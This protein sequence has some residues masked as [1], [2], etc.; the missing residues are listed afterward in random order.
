MDEIDEEKIREDERKKIEKERKEERT[1]YFNDG[2]SYGKRELL[3]RLE[4]ENQ[5]MLTNE[6]KEVIEGFDIHKR[7]IGCFVKKQR[8]EAKGR[9]VVDSPPRAGNLNLRP[10]KS[11]KRKGEK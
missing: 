10:A 9:A 1:F 8:K 7:M 2:V 5:C 11:L 3:D 4:R 6:N